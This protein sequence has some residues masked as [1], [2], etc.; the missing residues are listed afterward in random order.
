MG[1]KERVDR[2]CLTCQHYKPYRCMFDDHYIGYLYCDIPTKCRDYRLHENYRRGGK[3]YSLRPDKVV[4]Q[5]D[6]PAND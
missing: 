4:K 1:V 5:N 3:W 2:I 6:N